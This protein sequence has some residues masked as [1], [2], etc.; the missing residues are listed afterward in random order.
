MKDEDTLLSYSVKV[1]DCIVL[2]ATKPKKQPIAKEKEPV[3][4][5]KQVEI[6]K[7]EESYAQGTE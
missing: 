6:N 7:P 5:Q 1:N 4:V 2:M 3:I